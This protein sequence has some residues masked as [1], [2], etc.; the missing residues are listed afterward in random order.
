M[1][2]QPDI[3]GANASTIRP[4]VSDAAATNSKTLAI[5]N[6]VPTS[7]W[8]AIATSPFEPN[9]TAHCNDLF[10]QASTVV[11][12]TSVERRAATLTASQRATTVQ[13]TTAPKSTPK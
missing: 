11:L 4:I 9:S 6:Q 3:S 1:I 8:I 7:N 10:S 5:R 2:V 13:M 12:R